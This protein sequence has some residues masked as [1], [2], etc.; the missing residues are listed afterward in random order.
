MYCSVI[1][2]NTGLH[3]VNTNASGRSVNALVVREADNGHER[4]KYRCNA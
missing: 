1:V 4:G 3:T 2:V